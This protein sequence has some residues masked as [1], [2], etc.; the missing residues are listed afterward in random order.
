[1]ARFHSVLAKCLPNEGPY[2]IHGRKS[3][4]EVNMQQTDVKDGIAANDNRVGKVI[5]IG[6]VFIKSS[7][8]HKALGE[9]YEK[10][11]G[12]QI[13]N[14]GFA[15]IRTPDD[16][17]QLAGKTIWKPFEKDAAMF[18]GSK[19][20]AMINYQVDNLKE[21]YDRLKKDDVKD[22]GEIMIDQ[23]GKFLSVKDPEGNTF[24]LWEPTKK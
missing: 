9:W 18:D 19:S 21:I 6:G 22:V 3:R 2:Y 1:M 5:D 17:R 15:V 14:F 12:M 7:G 13:N 16:K 8:D 23:F 20:N 24:Q 4:N 10:Y 11:L